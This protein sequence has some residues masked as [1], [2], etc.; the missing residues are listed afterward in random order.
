MSLT[1]ILAWEGQHDFAKR[2]ERCLNREDGPEIIRYDEEAEHPSSDAPMEA[3]IAFISTSALRRY[4]RNHLAWERIKGIPV[5]WVGSGDQSVYT[6]TSTSERVVLPAYF[7]CASLDSVLRHT[8]RSSPRFGM[9]THPAS[10]SETPP[11]ELPL[12]KEGS[13]IYQAACMQQLV[14]NSRLYGALSVSVLIRGGSGTGKE[15]IA[16]MVADAHPTY[17]NGPFVAVNCAAIPE[18]LFESLFFGHVKGSFT[19]AVRDHT[20]YF[21]DAHNG[22]LYLDEIGDL[23]FYHQVKL[24]RALDDG[25]IHPVGSS[26]NI[27][28]N[29]R[30][31]AAT[32]RPLNRMIQEGTFRLDFYHRIAVVEL[33]VPTLQERGADE[34]LLLFHAAMRQSLNL[35]A[36][37]SCEPPELP[38]WLKDWVTSYPFVGNVRELSNKAARMAAYYLGHHRFEQTECMLLLCPEALECEADEIEELPDFSSRTEE[39]AQVLQALEQ[40]QWRRS[41]TA[42]ALGWSRKT[43]WLKMKKYRLS[44]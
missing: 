40:N 35:Y 41:E 9:D 31:V 43:L 20:G 10:T 12:R 4:D 13:F 7:N 22:T 2:L 38:L 36:Q 6:A 14:A 23:P 25:V 33:Y 28:T 8:L 15:H 42:E 16:R 26:E 30:L 3:D 19:G 44:D 5:I 1:Q 29:F 32:N 18:T 21:Q 17:R 11:V 24:L 37:E 34:K 39:R 27:R